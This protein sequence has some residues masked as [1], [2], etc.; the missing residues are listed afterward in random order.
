VWVGPKPTE[1]LQASRGRRQGQRTR[2]TKTL[3]EVNGE[4][5]LKKRLT[6][7]TLLEMFLLVKAG[8]TPADALRAATL[9]IAEFLGLQN[10]LGT[11]ETGKFADLVLLD[12]NPFEDIRNT[13]KISGVFLQGRYFNRQALDRLLQKVETQA[14]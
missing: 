9:D 5:R 13:Q 6:E 2:R 4:V 12:A 3:F 8:L 11:V 7:P 1:R 10:S 14:R